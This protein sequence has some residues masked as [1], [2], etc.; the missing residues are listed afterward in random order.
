MG[1]VEGELYKLIQE[2]MVTAPILEYGENQVYRAILM[3]DLEEI[4]NEVKQD[5]EKIHDIVSEKVIIIDNAFPNSS[6]LHNIAWDYIE[7]LEREKWFKKWF[8]GDV[9]K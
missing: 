3:V 7:R 4:L 9:E 2:K 5:W 8:G 1:A 6:T